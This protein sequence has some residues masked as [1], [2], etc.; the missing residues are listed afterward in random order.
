[1]ISNDTIMSASTQHP[2]VAQD[3][4]LCRENPWRLALQCPYHR[5]IVSM[6]NTISG[7]ATHFLEAQPCLFE[8]PTTRQLSTSRQCVCALLLPERLVNELTDVAIQL[9][10]E[11]I[12]E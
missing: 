9:A 7:T 8:I 10:T 5:E 12:K 3:I 4:I 1:V 11:D 2:I 6:Q